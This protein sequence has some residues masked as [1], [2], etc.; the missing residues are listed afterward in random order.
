MAKHTN[1]VQLDNRLGDRDEVK[2]VGEGL[3]LEGSIKGSHNHN[4][5]IVGHRLTKIDQ[6]REEL[7]FIDTNH[8]HANRIEI[9][10]FRA[11]GSL[12]GL[13]IVGG[14]AIFGI[15]LVGCVFDNR[16]FVV[17]DGVTTDTA[18][19]LFPLNMGP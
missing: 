6:V 19:E 4:L 16:A 14:G 12:P 13:F 10:Q 7:T 18:E 15:T 1:S 8:I 3:H 11:A 5:A 9:F 17:G 2:D